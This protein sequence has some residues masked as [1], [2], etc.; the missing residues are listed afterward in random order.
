LNKFVI[1]FEVEY[2]SAF[3][4]FADDMYFLP[5]ISMDSI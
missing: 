3:D 4:I 5:S 2:S 1:D